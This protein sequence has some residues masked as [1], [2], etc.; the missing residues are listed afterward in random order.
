[1]KE[2]KETHWPL[3]Y[4]KTK[5]NGTLHEKQAISQLDNS[6]ITDFLVSGT[7][8]NKCLLFISHPVCDI[9]L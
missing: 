9:L 2:T 5:L 8:G 1:M 4:G 7:V 6:F 3:V